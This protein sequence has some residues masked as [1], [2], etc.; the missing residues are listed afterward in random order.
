VN[1]I[2]LSQKRIQMWALWIW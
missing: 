2:Q 1:F